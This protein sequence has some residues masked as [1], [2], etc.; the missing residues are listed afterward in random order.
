MKAGCIPVILSSDTILPFSEKLDWTKCSLS[1]PKGHLDNLFDVI[2]SHSTDEITYLR[3]HVNFFYSKYMSSLGAIAKT[4]LDI[5]NSRVFPH[6]AKSYNEWNDPSSSLQEVPSEVSFPSNG[7]AI[8]NGYALIVATKS[9][10][11]YLVPLLSRISQSRYMQEAYIIWLG[12]PDSLAS[13]VFLLLSNV[14][15]HVLP[16]LYNSKEQ[17]VL[18]LPETKFSSFLFLTEHAL[19]PADVT[20]VDFAYEAWCQHPNRVVTIPSIQPTKS[21]SEEASFDLAFFHKVFVVRLLEL[22][23]DKLS[24]LISSTGSCAEVVLPDM[25]VRLSGRPPIHVSPEKHNQ[26]PAGV[27]PDLLESFSV[28][29]SMARLRQECLRLPGVRRLLPNHHKETFTFMVH[30]Y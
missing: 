16:P 14:T 19:I 9:H 24:G 23:P 20:A 28:N 11:K 13:S 7:D 15:V 30:P 10:I 3:R 21:H 4:T 17:S 12:E 5:I 27:P 18:R 26:T 1:V 2:S 22:L 29:S 6:Y 25:V 8:C